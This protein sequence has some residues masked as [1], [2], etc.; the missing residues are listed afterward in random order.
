MSTA[1][2]ESRITALE[3]KVATLAEDRVNGT[4]PTHEW[5]NK[6]FG[7]F[8]DDPEFEEAVKA[9]REWRKAVAVNLS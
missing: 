9:G 6:V 3:R 2:L 5:L 4:G 8:A 7:V 1:E